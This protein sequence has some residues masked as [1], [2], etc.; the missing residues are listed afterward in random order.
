VQV[1]DVEP[2]G[3][4]FQHARRLLRLTLWEIA[5]KG[6]FPSA[7]WEQFVYKI[8]VTTVHPQPCGETAVLL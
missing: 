5:S 7:C 6:A 8:S 4:A 3:P 2:L 1:A